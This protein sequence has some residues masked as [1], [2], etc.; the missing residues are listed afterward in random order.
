MT[1]SYSEKVA[2]AV[3]EYVKKRWW[4]L[5]E[6]GLL[7]RELHGGLPFVLLPLLFALNLPT[8]GEVYLVYGSYYLMSAS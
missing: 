5:G 7:F 1:E 8:I 6:G 2:R 4:Y 3:R